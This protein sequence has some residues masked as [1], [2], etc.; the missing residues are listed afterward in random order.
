[1]Y[2]DARLGQCKLRNAQQDSGKRGVCLLRRT[3]T[4]KV[5]MP[6][7]RC[8]GLDSK[9]YPPNRCAVPTCRGHPLSLNTFNNVMQTNDKRNIVPPET[10]PLI[11]FVLK[12]P[13]H[14]IIDIF[15]N[16]LGSYSNQLVFSNVITTG[17]SVCMILLAT[18]LDIILQ[19]AMSV[20]CKRQLYAY[21]L[22]VLGRIAGIEI[23]SSVMLRIY[24][25]GEVVLVR[26]A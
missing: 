16:C 26:V 23:F 4:F 22:I 25:Q 3:R 1:M 6:W 18:V 11:V 8:I 15:L 12:P 20:V 2:P 14:E 21:R 13:T 17:M 10:I 9:S 24:C 19:T 5:V 7:E